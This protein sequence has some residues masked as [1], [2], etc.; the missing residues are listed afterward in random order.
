MASI[1]ARN[2]RPVGQDT[3]DAEDRY[4]H[5]LPGTRRP[6]FRVVGTA[7]EGSPRQ[8]EHDRDATERGEKHEQ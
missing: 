7:E 4:A 8:R 1:G 5:H 2:P 6:F 3:D